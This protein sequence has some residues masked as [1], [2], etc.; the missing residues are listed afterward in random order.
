[1]HFL[2]SLKSWCLVFCLAGLGAICQKV[3][4]Q[5]RLLGESNPKKRQNMTIGLQ[6][7][8]QIQKSVNSD[9]I[10]CAVHAIEP[11]QLG[12]LKSLEAQ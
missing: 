8:N 11:L 5:A 9:C 4:R 1:M 7:V 3:V 12:A 6:I 2:S 10:F